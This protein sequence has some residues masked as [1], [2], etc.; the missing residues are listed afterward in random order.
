MMKD[1]I[2][3]VAQLG[4]KGLPLG[5]DKSFFLGEELTILGLKVQAPTGKYCIGSKALKLLLD[6]Q[7]P[8]TIK[9]LQGLLSKFNFCRTFILDNQRKVRPLLSLL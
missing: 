1:S 5:A 6:A 8:G 4:A 9:E 7:L 2:L 3:A